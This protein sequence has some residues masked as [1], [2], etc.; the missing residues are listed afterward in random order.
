MQSTQLDT[1]RRRRASHLVIHHPLAAL[2]VACVGLLLAPAA[3]HAA[4]FVIDAAKTDAPKCGTAA[5]TACKT[6][7][8]WYRSGCDAD[9]CGNNV[10]PG[11]TIA[12]RAG[13][14]AGDGGGGYIAIPFKGTAAAPITVAC[15]D[16]PGSCVISG[17][18]LTPVTWCALVG[19]GLGGDNTYCGT[20]PAQYVVVR[21]FRVEHIPSGMYG[22]AIV[23]ASHHVLLDSLTVDGAGAT[24][25]LFTTNPAS[26]HVTLKHSTLSNCPASD[27]GCTYMDSSA[28]LAEVGNQF[29]PVGNDG[30]YDCNTVLD[31]DTGLIDGNTCTGSADGFDEGMH[32]A[33]PLRNMIV[34]SNVVIGASSRA[35]PLSGDRHD[36][37]KDTGANILYKNLAQPNASGGM[38]RCL[39]LY[40]GAN[41]IDLWYNTCFGSTQAGYGDLLW[42]NPRGDY[43]NFAVQNIRVRYS[44]FDTTSTSS[45]PPLVLDQDGSTIVGCPSGAPCPLTKNAVWMGERGGGGACVHWDPSDQPLAD[46][47]CQE[48]GASF[49]SNGRSGN[50][51]ADPHF[52]NRGAPSVL[53]NLRLTAASAGYLDAGGAFCRTTSA[54]SGTTIPV[55]CDGVSTDP[56]HY[57]PDPAN[58]YQLANDDCRGQG[59]RA[60]DAADAGCFDVQIEG[61]CGVR[62]IAAMAATSLSVSGAACAWNAGAMVHVPWSGAA[63][64]LGALEAPAA[65][66]SR[67]PAPRLLSVQPTP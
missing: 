42:L 30:N 52:S 13:T 60:A 23:E 28:N 5:A 21:G 34:R 53:A 6:Y 64:D 9:G 33:A 39:E 29:G 26:H 47:S 61:G 62:Q 41:G 45:N 43:S 63:P 58:F 48:F 65:A 36:S 7:R 22:V 4:T 51:R 49:N 27:T 15:Q 19:V 1:A 54:G 35:F 31:V 56:R 59:T 20:D 44:V 8:Y 66:A 37:G 50:F 38:G 14:Y 3:V 67:P 57:F 46:F 25:G 18:G 12:F 2:L 11:D 32:T 24:H 17:A 10:A 40:E 55:V 16:A